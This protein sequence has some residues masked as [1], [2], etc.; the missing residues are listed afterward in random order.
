MEEV[1]LYLPQL[2]QLVTSDDDPSDFES[3]SSML[4]RAGLA[5]PIPVGHYLYWH[6]TTAGICARTR[7]GDCCV[8]SLA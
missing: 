4:L 7:V 3:V 1:L 6:L 8:L 5:S 2:T